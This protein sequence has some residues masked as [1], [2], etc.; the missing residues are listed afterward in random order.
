MGFGAR[1]AGLFLIVLALGSAEAFA[2]PSSLQRREQKLQARLER[3][4]N[5]VKKAKLEVR[6]GRL[7]LQQAFAAYDRSDFD[8]CWKQLDDYLARMRSAWASLGASGRQAYRKPDGFKQLDIALRESRRDLSDFETRVTFE[9]RQHVEKIKKQTEQLRNQVLNA[10]FPQGPP[11]KKRTRNA[12][13][14]R[15]TSRRAEGLK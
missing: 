1:V 5:P 13:R 10:L 2:I 11:P 4:H 7:K 6:L 15:L 3:E 12:S 9:E 14:P 8:T